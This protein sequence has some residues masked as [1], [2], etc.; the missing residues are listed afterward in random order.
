MFTEEILKEYSSVIFLNTTGEV[1][2]NAQQAEFERYIQAGGGFV[3]I[4]A[5]LDIN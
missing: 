4:I 1:L 3:G 5:G 2:N